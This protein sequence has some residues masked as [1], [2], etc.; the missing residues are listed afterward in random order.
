MFS[1]Q[2]EFVGYDCVLKSGVALKRDRSQPVAETETCAAQ[3]VW[4][5]GRRACERSIMH[6][7][8]L[9]GCTKVFRFRSSVREEQEV[10]TCLLINSGIQS[11][12]P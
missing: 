5:T 1:L 4:P 7:F 12:S 2:L 8:G 3:F 9:A 10:L 6:R 11:K